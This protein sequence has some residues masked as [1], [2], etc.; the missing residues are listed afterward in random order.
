MRL[1][2]LIEEAHVALVCACHR[3]EDGTRSRSADD[4][5]A[6]TRCAQEARRLAEE[7]EA[8]CW[9]LAREFAAPKVEEADAPESPTPAR[10]GRARHAAA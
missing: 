6:A 9:T 2:E 3:I 4:L 7:L 8:A 5:E 10:R 1:F